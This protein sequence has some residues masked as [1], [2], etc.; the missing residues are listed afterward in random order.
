MIDRTNLFL[1]DEIPFRWLGREVLGIGVVGYPL[2]RPRRE[3]IHS[4]QESR[5]LNIKSTHCYEP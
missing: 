4:N 3:S 1:V 5:L 2:L